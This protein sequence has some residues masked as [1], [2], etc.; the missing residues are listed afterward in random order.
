VV[1]VMLIVGW[2]AN[3]MQREITNGG[4]VTSST[5]LYYAYVFYTDF[6]AIFIRILYLLALAKNNN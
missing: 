6:I 5:A 3:R 4:Y 2:D 1:A